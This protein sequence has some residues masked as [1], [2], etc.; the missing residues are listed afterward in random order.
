MKT[1]K[2]VVVMATY[3]EAK[4]IKQILDYLTK[5]FFVVI[6]DDNSEDGTAEI[7]K[8]F[9]TKVFL[10]SR[11]RKLGIASAYYEGFKYAITLGSP[12]IIQMDAGLTHNPKDVAGLVTMADLSGAKLVVAQRDFKVK[13]YRTIL[14]ILAAFFMSLL[15]I[16]LK[17]VTTG[18]RCWNTALLS[19]V[20][21]FGEFRSKGFAFQLETL[22]RAVKVLEFNT[23]LYK[24]Y[25][26]DYELTNSTFNLKMIFEAVKI[27]LLFLVRRI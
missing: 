6:V 7:I 20:L 18:F 13:G 21:E 26:I 24:G 2:P 22:Y 14:S 27:Y 19:R 9:G 23:K 12:Y 3:N 4:T 17:D 10:I 8:S 11:P 5:Y 1:K 16:Q 25:P 15:G